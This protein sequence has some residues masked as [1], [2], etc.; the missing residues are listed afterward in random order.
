[1]TGRPPTRRTEARRLLAKLLADG[2]RPG[3]EV[4]AAAIATGDYHGV[5][6]RRSESACRRFESCLRHSETPAAG[7]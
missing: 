7:A 1:M 4:R 2:P 6:C 3:R 5:A